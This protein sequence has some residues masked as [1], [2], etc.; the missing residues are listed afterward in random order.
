[1][2]HPDVLPMPDGSDPSPESFRC[3]VRLFYPVLSRLPGPLRKIGLK[4]LP[5]PWTKP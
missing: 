1:M 2:K 4:M 3:H 5:M